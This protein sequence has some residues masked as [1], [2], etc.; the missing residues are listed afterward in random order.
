MNE[1]RKGGTFEYMAPEL[2]SAG[3]NY[4]AF[5]EKCD[6]FSFAILCWEMVERDIP[7]R[8][9]EKDAILANLIQGHRLPF[10]NNINADPNMTRLIDRCWHQDSTQRPSFE[11]I[12]TYILETIPGE[13]RENT[14]LLDKNVRESDRRNKM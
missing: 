7:Y 14:L 5:N 1:L 12:T 13:N 9:R 11:E 4:V 8:G 2:L 3:F 10:K 6:V